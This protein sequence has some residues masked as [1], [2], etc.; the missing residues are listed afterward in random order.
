MF[1]PRG[2]ILCFGL[3]I[4]AA[5]SVIAGELSDVHLKNGLH[6]R[7]DVT[8]EGDRITL[9]NLAGATTILKTEIASIVVVERETDELP[10]LPDVAP[11]A[12]STAPATSKPA[13]AS[14]ADDDGD[15]IDAT[16]PALPA[17]PMVSPRDILRLKLS[18]LRLD[19]PAE[20]LRAKF[21]PMKQRR[22][23]AKEVL[24]DLQ[25]RGR[26]DPEWVKVLQSGGAYEKLQVIVKAT[27]LEHIERIELSGD[28]E[29]FATFRRRVNPLVQRG[30]ARG[31]C[32]GATGAE[33]FRLPSGGGES[34][35]SAYTTF[36]LLE[37]LRANG[38][39]MI[40]RIDPSTAP[41]LKYLVGTAPGEG[42]HPAVAGKRLNPPLKTTREPQ[43]RA[44]EAWL[45]SLRSPHPEYQLDYDFVPTAER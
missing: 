19:G 10:R 29:V 39:S 3:L 28:P 34:D 14:A 9:R 42:G 32:H 44:V 8:D 43:Y 30:C 33:V 31:G 6:L 7:G 12:T 22:D 37:R 16:R 2:V 40:D 15:V 27:G 4:F 11:P 23:L 17:P 45:G 24:A 25:K 18:E 5:C 13:D 21:L 35:A 36:V 1:G 41:L 20:E 38:R 26:V